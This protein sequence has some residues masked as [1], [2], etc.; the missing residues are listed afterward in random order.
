MDPFRL[1]LAM[2]P[3][4]VYLIVLGGMNLMRR[5]FVV[6]GTRDTAALGLAVFGLFLVGPF[7]LFYPSSASTLFGSFVWVFLASL[8]GLS[9]VLVLLSQRPRLVV[10]NIAVDELRAI[11]A[12]LVEGFEGIEGLEGETQWAG[13]SLS[14][15]KLGLQLHIDASSAMRNVSLVSSGPHQNLMG[16][17]KLQLELSKALRQFKVRR[18]LRAG[19][20]LLS[21]LAIS[22]L[23]MAA[24]LHDPQLVAKSMVEMFTR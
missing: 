24:V 15:P 2:G 23:L 16:W 19:W 3:V 12:D 14:L 4:A 9:V 20:L 13:N 1:C 18:N 5:P 6:S 8:Y 7:E 17:R 11:M 21:G 22:Y 10:Y